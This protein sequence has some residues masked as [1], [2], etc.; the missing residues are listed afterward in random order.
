MDIILKMR[1]VCLFQL[2]IFFFS[3][4]WDEIRIFYF[5]SSL[6]GIISTFMFPYSKKILL[7][8]QNN[9]ISSSVSKLNINISQSILYTHH[10]SRAQLSYR[11]IVFIIL[12][13]FI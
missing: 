6:S 1:I 13:L 7:Y 5:T 4:L 3:F 8:P 9:H 11:I 12:S 2:M 10:S